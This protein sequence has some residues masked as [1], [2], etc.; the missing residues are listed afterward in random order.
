MPCSR[1]GDAADEQAWC[2]LFAT[3]TELTVQAVAEA[4]R[5]HVLPVAG[6]VRW[7]WRAAAAPAIAR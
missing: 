2:D 6:R 4:Y 5:R 7:S 1:A 3:V